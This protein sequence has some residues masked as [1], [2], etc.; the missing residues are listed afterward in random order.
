M[1]RSP[2]WV[3]VGF[4]KVKQR[5]EQ[6]GILLFTGYALV[7]GVSRRHTKT[8][9]GYAQGYSETETSDRI[10][11][12]CLG[13]VACS[14][15]GKPQRRYALD[16]Q[17]TRHNDGIVCTLEWGQLQVHEGKPQATCKSTAKNNNKTSTRFFI[18]VSVF[19]VSCRYTQAGPRLGTH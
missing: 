2:G 18:H 4:Q 19:G 5:R 15:E 17:D 16:G 10:T 9:S 11:C 14:P 6:R 1:K 13:P 3:R 8:S 12:R 7:W